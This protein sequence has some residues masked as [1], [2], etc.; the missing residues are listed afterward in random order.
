MT[1]EFWISEALLSFITVVGFFV[2]WQFI[3]AKDGMLRKLMIG[4]FSVEV[5]I[6]GTSALYFYG[7]AK[8]FVFTPIEKIRLI[9]LIP[10]AFI[11]ILLLIWLLKNRQ[12]AK[13]LQ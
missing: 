6:Y 2:L 7:T 8:H 3:I 13:T 12:K 11:K 4:Y 5:F 9:L 10:K 1:T